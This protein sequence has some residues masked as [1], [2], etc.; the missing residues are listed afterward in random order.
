MRNQLYH[1]C[2]E[3]ILV[4]LSRHNTKVI[5]H[6]DILDVKWCTCVNEL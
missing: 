5:K 2:E 3:Y 1:P 6:Y 4:H